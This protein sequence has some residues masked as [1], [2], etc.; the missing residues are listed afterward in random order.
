VGLAENNVGGRYDLNAPEGISVV[1]MSITPNLKPTVN[2]EYRFNQNTEKHEI[3]LAKR[4]ALTI[5]FAEKEKDVLP[6]EIESILLYPV[7]RAGKS[8][9]QVF[10][11]H[12][13]V[14]G[15]S[16]PRK[17]VAKFQ[18]KAAT[19]RELNSA[20]SAFFGQICP[21]VSAVIDEPNNLG[22]VVYD[23][24]KIPNHCEFRG[25][26]LDINHTDQQCASALSSVFKKIGRLPNNRCDRIPF[27][28][29]YEWYIKRK[30]EPL[31]RINS[32][33][34]HSGSSFGV[35]DLAKS[36]NHH[37]STIVRRLEEG[38]VSVFPYLVHGDLH[39][40]NL[41]LNVDDP[42]QT[43]LIDF[44]W[45][46][47]GHPAKDFTLMESTLKYM[48]LHE[49]LPKIDRSSGSALHMPLAAFD[50][51]EQYLCTHGLKL[52]AVEE[53]E[54]HMER[55]HGLQDHHLIGLRRVYISL[56]VLRKAASSVLEK[57]C[58]N[59]DNGS[60]LSVNQHY[61]ISHFLLTL[62]LLGFEE[63]EPIWTLLGLHIIGSSIWPS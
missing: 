15:V 25:F 3:E 19:E 37:Y 11:L 42:T 46:H 53:F 61:L 39:A 34:A 62:G 1:R 20:K 24:V 60:G 40:R 28:K 9:S 63:M 5:N 32:Y 27:L 56:I 35:A 58:N 17:Y 30:K 36:I 41:I 52:P 7:Q 33:E 23:L 47:H 51:F 16:Y 26:F 43:E 50:C 6:G 55:I 54:K 2:F 22:M 38:E 44:D 48:L 45:V 57:Y 8:N 4:N 49:L 21:K 13:Y 14:K 31:N 12:I 18:S 29:D 10:Y 59:H